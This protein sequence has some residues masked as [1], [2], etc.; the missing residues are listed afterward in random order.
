M[1][2]TSTVR[3]NTYSGS[4]ITG[5]YPFTFR[6]YVQQ[7]LVVQ[8][9]DPSG[10]VTTLL[11][12][13]DYAIPAASIGARTGG[14]V[15]L[16]NA[17]GVG[18]T[19]TLSRVLPFTQLINYRNQG[20]TFPQNV[21]DGFDQVVMICQQLNDGVGALIEEVTTNT[22]NITNLTSQVT[23]NTT[24][25]TNL[26]T[27]VNNHSSSITTINTHLSVVDNEITNLTVLIE[28]GVPY[29][30]TNRVP[31]VYD[32][33]GTYSH[34]VTAGVTNIE[35][36][37]IGGGGGG[38]VTADLGGFD[39]NGG[40][41]GGKVWARK[42]VNGDTLTI[43]VGA[44]GTRGSGAGGSGTG[45]DGGDSTVNGTMVVA[46]GG[47]N[48]Q[49]F[50]GSGNPTPG[51]VASS[52]LASPILWNG[53]EGS[54]GGAGTSGFAEYTF[55][56]APGG[57]EGQPGMFLFFQI[58]SSSAVCYAARQ[59]TGPGCG[60]TPASNAT[61]GSDATVGRVIVWEYQ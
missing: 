51:G 50:N 18:W 42:V 12:G 28:E 15:T 2:V 11:Y 43:V 17:L 27:T 7:N 45:T 54:S 41:G 22:T 38:D 5:P 39:N 26:T 59:P 21:E 14:S 36:E 32:T 35:I 60:A 34:T 48:G 13:R 37:A 25:I 4:N 24:N 44:A 6:I 56:G 53:G 46:G 33:A 58:P 47:K 40:S 23:T 49:P 57:G 9:T 61:K 29:R 20:A 31:F 10:T 3:V 8:T 52:T 16:T 55:G 19:L 1:T 30:G